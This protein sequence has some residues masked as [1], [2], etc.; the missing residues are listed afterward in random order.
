MKNYIVPASEVV[1]YELEVEAESAEEAERQI[2]DG[3]I[4]IDL[5]PVDSSDFEVGK[6]REV[7]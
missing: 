7:K 5:I 2:R 3:E 4:K 6:A 1:Y